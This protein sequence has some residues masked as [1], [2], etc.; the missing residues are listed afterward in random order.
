MLLRTNAGAGSRRSSRA[1][2]EGRTVVAGGTSVGH[3]SLPWVTVGQPP[4]VGEIVV[5]QSQGVGQGGEH[6]RRG[7]PVTTLLQAHEVVDADPG[8]G[9]QLGPA[10]PWRAATRRDRQADVGRADRFAARAEELAELTVDHGLQSAGRGG[11]QGGP[12]GTSLDRGL[13]AGPVFADDR[14]HGRHDDHP[15]S[16]QAR[17]LGARHGP[18]PRRL[19]RPSPRRRQG[20]WALRRRRRHSSPIGS[21]V[22][23]TAVEATIGIASIDTGNSDRDAHVL[24]AELL[25]V[26]RRPTM[27]FRSTG[28]RGGADEWVLDGDLTIGDVTRPIAFDVELGGVADFVDGTRH[29]GFE[30]KG[31][32]RRKDFGI[33]FGPLNALLGD[34][35]K[36]ELDLEFIEPS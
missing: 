7:V 1:R 3:S 5:V 24:S 29:A 2:T 4:Q 17:L 23:E 10:Q 8:E 13:P 28:V 16:P 27:T 20:A 22:E 6:L 25:D 15:T 26:E 32:L 14:P 11:V 35:V 36:I 12:G 33:D 18:R 34:V 31:E 9:R 30:A 21:S 19:R